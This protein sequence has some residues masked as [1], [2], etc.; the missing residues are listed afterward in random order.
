MFIYFLVFFYLVIFS[1]RNTSPNTYG[2]NNKYITDWTLTFFLILIFIGARFEVGGDWGVYKYYFKTIK[3]YPSFIEGFKIDIIAAKREIGYFLINWIGR[4]IGG[5]FFINSICALIF[6]Y[7]LF[8][9][10]RVMPNPWL[11]LLTAYPYLIVVVAMG[12]VRQSVALGLIMLGLTYIF[13]M[14]FK[15]YIVIIFFASIFHVTSSLFILL[16]LL[17]K[18]FYSKIN[19][20]IFCIIIICFYYISLRTG[21]INNQFKG[22]LV[23]YLMGNYNSKGTFVRIIM[24]FLPSILFFLYQRRFN[25]SYAENRVWFFYSFIT[26][27]IFILFFYAPASA[28]IDRFMLYMIPLTIFFYSSVPVVFSQK[29]KNDFL[30]ILLIIVYNFLV[31]YIWLNYAVHS[32]AW[33]PYDSYF[34]KIFR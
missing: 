28:G 12:Y 14:K 25:L 5:I 19:I 24:C 27:L 2:F 16:I 10:C 11:A 7:C 22:M 17:F 31:L 34:F 32:F 18:E 21:L 8:K 13:R 4:N 29:N 23:N 6:T 15:S 3:N 26:I 33:L 20:I 30:L 1:I 9:F